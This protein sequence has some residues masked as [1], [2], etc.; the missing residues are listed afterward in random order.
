MAIRIF[1]IT[2][3]IPQILP[4]L[5]WFLV[6]E[7]MDEGFS[8]YS[9][10]WDDI[11]PLSSYFYWLIY[12]LFGT[13]SLAIQ[14]ITTLLILLQAFMLNHFL[15]RRDIFLDRT[16]V[17]ILL[18]LTLTNLFIDYYTLSP[19]LLANTFLIITIRYIFLHINERK[20]YNAVFE[21][22]AYIGLATLF[23]LPSFL[24]LLVPLVVFILYTGTA[25]KDYLLMLFAFLFTIGIAFLGFYLNNSEYDFYLNFFQ[26][27]FYLKPHFYVSFVDLI[28]LMALPILFTLLGI[29]NTH[30]YRRYTN[31][32]HRSQ[33]VMTFWLIIS[34]L[35]MFIS[36]KISSYSFILVIPAIVFIL[37]H[38]LLMLRNTFYKEAIYMLI[39]LSSLYFLFSTLYKTPLKINIPIAS[40][41][42]FEISVSTDK[43]L[44]KPHPKSDLIRGKRILVLG[45]ALGNYQGARVASP[46]LNWRLAQRHID[47]IDRYFNI[48]TRV[49]SNIFD[50]PQKDIPEIIVDVDGTAP[51]LFRHLPLAAQQYEKIPNTQPVLYARKDK[52]TS[53]DT[54]KTTKKSQR[55]ASRE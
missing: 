5:G 10:I 21:I 55:R 14:I 31:Y 15:R 42:R 46:Y 40:W 27:L 6:V 20:K 16:Q 4:E 34:F 17:P 53:E 30:L 23:Y 26:S 25:L 13:E 8:L 22:G 54:L 33:F 39:L 50:N 51:V 12:R 32:Q 3:G 28:K 9:E 29:F 48:K 36:S 7:R 24:M 49:Y 52:Q 41:T 1:A 47:N 19:V 44:V 11:S 18:Y 45:N 43:L 38:Y 35:T 37:S 2:L